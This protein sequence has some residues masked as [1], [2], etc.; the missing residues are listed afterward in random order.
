MPDIFPGLLI[1]K[2]SSGIDHELEY[3][4]LKWKAESPI[5]VV[6]EPSVHN[7]KVLKL[8]KG[9]F[10]RQHQKE[11]PLLFGARLAGSV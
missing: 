5:S 2:Y 11:R 8:E 4:I 7:H 10:F 9:L 6:K 1:L 3:K